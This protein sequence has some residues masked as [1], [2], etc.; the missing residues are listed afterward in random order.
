MK[1]KIPDIFTE[2]VK[3]QG[4]IDILTED[5]DTPSIMIRHTNMKMTLSAV[6]HFYIERQMYLLKKIKELAREIP[7][8]L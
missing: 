4:L 7:D 6:R 2:Y 5:L 1:H 3:V 8:S